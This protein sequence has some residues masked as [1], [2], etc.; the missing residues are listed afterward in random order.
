MLMLRQVQRRNV[1]FRGYAAAAWRSRGPT[2]VPARWLQPASSD[3]ATLKRTLQ[4]RTSR[5]E[6]Q[7][8][9]CAVD[10]VERIGVDCT[11]IGTV[12]TASLYSL[13]GPTLAHRLVE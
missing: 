6:G 12:V 9:E 2:L 7:L 8:F 4:G 3:P 13:G 10:L 5:I 11:H 1:R